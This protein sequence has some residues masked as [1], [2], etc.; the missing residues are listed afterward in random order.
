MLTHKH[1]ETYIHV[2]I[3]VATNGL[4][5]KHQAISNHSDE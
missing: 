4:V 3:S 5:P 1:L 2:F